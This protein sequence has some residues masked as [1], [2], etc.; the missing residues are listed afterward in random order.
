MGSFCP[1]TRLAPLGG[2]RPAAVFLNSYGQREPSA[3]KTWTKPTRT[4]SS[5]S[6]MINIARVNPRWFRSRTRFETPAATGNATVPRANAWKLL[7]T[8]DKAGPGEGIQESAERNGPSGA[9]HE[10]KDSRP[11]GLCGSSRRTL[12][13]RFATGK[14]HGQERNRPRDGRDDDQSNERLQTRHSR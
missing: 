2:D 7:I 9:P 10:Q 5:P 1:T 4:G 8:L 6:S 11:R 3:R 14:V 12:A 13:L